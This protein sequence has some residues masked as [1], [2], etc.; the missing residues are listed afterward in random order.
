MYDLFVFRG[1]APLPARLSG[2][3]LDRMALAYAESR[4]AEMGDSVEML[5]RC[6]AGK[7][8]QGAAG[9]AAEEGG[10]PAAGDTTVNRPGA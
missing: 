3:E 2:L 6:A 8:E 5:F 1:N 7:A 10:R 4:R 9:E